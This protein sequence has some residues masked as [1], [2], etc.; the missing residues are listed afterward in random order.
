MPRVNSWEVVVTCLIKSYWFT[1]SFWGDPEGGQHV[2]QEDWIQPWHRSLRANLRLAWRQ[3]VGAFHQHVLVQRMV[4]QE[5]QGQEGIL[6]KDPPGRPGQHWPPKPPHRQ[7]SPSS[8]PGC[9]QD[10]RWELR[11]NSK[12]FKLLK[13]QLL[14]FI[15]TFQIYDWCPF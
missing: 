15:L 4:R 9:L 12:D 8:P 14:K 3:H 13:L 7:A 1:G 10:R 2:H 5:G 6:R 11:V